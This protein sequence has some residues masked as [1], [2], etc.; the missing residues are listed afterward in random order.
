MGK[1]KIGFIEE[2]KSKKGLE[3]PMFFFGKVAKWWLI[4]GLVL[5]GF[6]WSYFNIAPFKSTVKSF[7]PKSAIAFVL[8]D[9]V[10]A[11]QKIRK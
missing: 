11:K 9:V 7:V 8:K 3:K 1:K 4:V 6:A 2:L 5:T 10:D